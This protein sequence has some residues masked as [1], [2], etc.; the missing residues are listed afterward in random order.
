VF[1][2]DPRAPRAK[3]GAAG[4]AVAGNGLKFFL[5]ELKAGMG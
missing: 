2:H 3:I 1:F 5:L 4:A